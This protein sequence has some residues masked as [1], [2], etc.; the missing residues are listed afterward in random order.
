MAEILLVQSSKWAYPRVV[1]HKPGQNT[2]V[3]SLSQARFQRQKNDMWNAN[4]RPTSE[5]ALLMGRYTWLWSFL[6]PKA[7]VPSR[8]QQNLQNSTKKNFLRGLR[9][10][11]IQKFFTIRTASQIY[12]GIL[13]IHVTR[14][15]YNCPSLGWPSCMSKMQKVA[16][17]SDA[18][19]PTAG[20]IQ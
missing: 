5:R 10:G 1:Q 11:W 15:W 8:S 9:H 16:E 13:Y 12:N 17:E 7:S 19:K 3:Q 14:E 6:K 2:R 20:N 18:C 4:Q